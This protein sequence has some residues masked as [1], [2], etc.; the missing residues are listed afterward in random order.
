MTA[1]SS[2]A[3]RDTASVFS[4]IGQ[5][6]KDRLAAQ[7]ESEMF[8][9]LG[10]DQFDRMAHDLG[11]SADDLQEI[12]MSGA[13]ASDEAPHMMEA[14]GLDP[15]AVQHDQRAVYLDVLRNCSHCD[16]KRRCDHD[17]TSGQAAA[18]FEEYCLN[19]YTLNALRAIA[20]MPPRPTAKAS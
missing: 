18:H 12:A 2:L 15:E 7:R 11:M 17:L 14:L 6:W 1:S 4:A 9:A 5:W 16:A 10:H 8:V 3:G 13:H 20:A 19:A